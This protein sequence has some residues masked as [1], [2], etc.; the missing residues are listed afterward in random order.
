M[1]LFSE[2]RRRQLPRTALFYIVSVW[3]VIQVADIV[4]PAFNASDLVLQT[5]IIV[6]I[7]GFPIVLVLAWLFDLTPQ[8]IQRTPV[9][10]TGPSAPPMQRRT[11]NLVV[12]ALLCVALLLMI[13]DNYVLSRL[14]TFEVVASTA[15]SRS[16]A[17]LPFKN[18]SAAAEDAEFFADGVHD[19]L[20]TLLSKFRGVR[21]IS[22]S[23]VDRFKDSDLTLEQIADALGT[24]RILEGGVQQA[25]DRVRINVQLVDVDFD[26]N[27]WAETYDRELT[28][29]NVFEIQAE[30]AEQ[31][32]HALEAE[33]TAA[34]RIQLARVPTENLAAYRAHLLGKERL[35]SLSTANLEQAIEHFEHAIE[36]D[37]AFAAAYIGL[38]DAYLYLIDFGALDER[39]ALMR[40][41]PFVEQALQLDPTFGEAHVTLGLLNYYDFD[42][43][44]AER[45]YLRALDL[46]PNYCCG[47]PMVRRPVD[48]HGPTGTGA[49]ASARRVVAGSVVT[50]V[51]ERNRRCAGR[52]RA[53]R[54]SADRARRRPGNA[55][56]ASALLLACGTHQCLRAGSLR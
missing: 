55:P 52:T 35:E 47:A 10:D 3:V 2:L 42:Y 39:E 26:R 31:I 44:A 50:R 25:G 19:D 33:L 43:P 14:E 54:R 37:P 4:L 24:T 7:L 38:A 15:P 8:G 16:L 30:I 41:T 1:S 22:R 46:K 13:V 20:L 34:E 6:C 29:V 21:V 49:G 51:G 28:A 27:I 56:R 12:I 40:A 17:V 18:R 11:A 9:Q 48:P 23:S 32:A 53:L 36:L 5:L 45:A